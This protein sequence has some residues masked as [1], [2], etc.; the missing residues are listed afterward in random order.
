[1][2]CYS[3]RGQSILSLLLF[4]SFVYFAVLFSLS[5]L[6]SISLYSSLSSCSSDN[7][8]CGFYS[9]LASSMRYRFNYWM[10]MF[11]FVIFDLELLLSL[12]LLFGLVSFSSNNLVCVL[13]S[14]LFIDLLFES[15][16]SAIVC[17]S[18]F[19]QSVFKA[20]DHQLLV[21]CGA[22]EGC[23]KQSIFYLL[24]FLCFIHIVD[25]LLTAFE[26]L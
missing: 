26:W 9:I 1:M 5:A 4:V 17:S 24:S 21:D 6:F 7:F 12:F 22:A 25:S 19:Y 2:I 3:F 20:V 13:L 23:R 8:E 15:S 16:L 11:H 18:L 14:L 10:V